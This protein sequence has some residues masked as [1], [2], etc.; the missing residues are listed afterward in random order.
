MSTTNIHRRALLAVAGAA[1]AT[2]AGAAR[3]QAAFPSRAVSIVVPYGAGSSTDILGRVLAPPL[4]AQLGQTVVVENRVGAGGTIGMGHVARSQPDG[5]TMVLT[6]ASAGPVNR[7]LFRNLGYDPVR[8]LS[9]VTLT[10]ISFNALVVPGNSPSST[11]ADF[12]ARAKAAGA[13]ALRYFSPGN[14]TSQHLSAVLLS[15]LLGVRM[16]HI[17]Y[18][19]PAEGL[20]A[21]MTNE[22]DFGF[23][24]LSSIVAMLR[25]G[26]VKVLGLTGRQR[27]R[28]LPDAPLLAEL[29]YAP[30]SDVLVWTGLAVPKATPQGIKEALRAAI[31]TVLDLPAT[32]DRFAQI[33]IERVPPM[34]L[35][36]MDAFM[37]QQL[38]LWDGLVRASGA[39][40]D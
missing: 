2:A 19:G 25:E 4:T 38:A 7:A 35:A 22:V 36:E 11:L 31:G 34:T 1:P 28:A 33:G 5:H 37:E 10:N 29:G 17:P 20:T 9:L 26:R 14:G 32:Q 30:F 13:P 3:A 23:A 6:S 8:D 40:V 39:R 18:R 12:A 16:E 15:Q 27:A 21:V 24:S